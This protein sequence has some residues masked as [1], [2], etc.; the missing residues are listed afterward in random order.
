MCRSKSLLLV[1][2]MTQITVIDLVYH[3]IFH[4]QLGIKITVVHYPATVWQKLNGVVA[5]K[6]TMMKNVPA[7]LVIFTIPCKIMIY[8]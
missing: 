8:A 3:T 1:F 6:N 4:H 7:H 5:A 2:L